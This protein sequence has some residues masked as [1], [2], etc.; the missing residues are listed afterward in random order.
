MPIEN[1]KLVYL[2]TIFLSKSMNLLKIYKLNLRKN[3]LDNY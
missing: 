2:K 3:G 1:S